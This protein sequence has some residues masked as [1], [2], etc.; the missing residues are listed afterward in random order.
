MN[1][2]VSGST[3]AASVLS[4]PTGVNST[5]RSRGHVS[6]VAFGVIVTPVSL[7][8][9]LSDFATKKLFAPMSPPK[10]AVRQKRQTGPRKL[11]TA[12]TTV[13]FVH[14]IGVL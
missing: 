7:F 11:T 9:G 12:L 8:T 5:V 2:R 13:D 10:K 3:A 14:I 1:A 6:K 4:V